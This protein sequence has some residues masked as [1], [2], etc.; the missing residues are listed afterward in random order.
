M[1]VLRL[2]S[3]L[4]TAGGL[5]NAATAVGLPGALAVTRHPG[6]CAPRTGFGR[7]S[8]WSERFSE[9]TRRFISHL[10]WERV[11]KRGMWGMQLR[12]DGNATKGARSAP[13]LFCN[14]AYHII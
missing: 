4:R 1:Y 11:K 3:C 14:N 12:V 6:A 2:R 8:P 7:Q 10:G 13:S 5:R 9:C